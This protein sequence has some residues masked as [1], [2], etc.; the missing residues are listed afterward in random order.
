MN[1]LLLMMAGS[2]SRFGADIPKQFTMIDGNPLFLAILKGYQKLDEIDHIVVVSHEAWIPQVQEWCQGIGK[3]IDIVAGGRNRSE[4][5]RNGLRAASKFANATDVVLI[6]DATHPY[7]DKEGTKK[8][9]EATQKSGAATLA[10]F[11]YDTVY[12]I[13]DKNNISEV[14]PRTRVVN[15]ASPE[16]FQFGI[17]YPVYE[18]ADDVELENMTSAGAIAL[19]NNIQMAFIQTDIL[20]LKITYKRDLDL[21]LRLQHY[22]FE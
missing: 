16:A 11:N 22:Y 3:V 5:V 15:G 14:L 18:N 8:V 2:G 13:D 7:V 9:I 6:H 1:I 17:I 20:N 21:Y 12:R 10:N 19:K 4:S